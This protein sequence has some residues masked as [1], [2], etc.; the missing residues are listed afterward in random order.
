MSDHH[1]RW[2]APAVFALAD[3]TAQLLLAIACVSTGLAL[4]NVVPCRHF[5]GGLVVVT[6]LRSMGREQGGMLASAVIAAS[7]TL[8]AVNAV[9][10]LGPSFA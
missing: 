6:L 7:T 9:L 10:L 3:L 8:F 2:Q 5:D 1:R 4:T